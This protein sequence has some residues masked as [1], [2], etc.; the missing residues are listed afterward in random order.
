[1][2]FRS[3]TTG[4]NY[5]G[6]AEDE[7]REKINELYAVIAGYF[8]APSISELSKLALLKSELDAAQKKYKA[9][10]DGKIKDFDKILDKNTSITKPV[11]STF[12]EFIKE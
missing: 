2:L 3:V 11:I 1:M 6:T 8:G 9:L 5:V 12:D 4:D 7:L 10:Q